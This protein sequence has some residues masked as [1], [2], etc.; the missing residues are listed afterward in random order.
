VEQVADLIGNVAGALREVRH[1]RAQDR[2]PARFPFTY[3][4]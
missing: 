1:V 3:S 4:S 2:V